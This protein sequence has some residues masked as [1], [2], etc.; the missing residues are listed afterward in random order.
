MEERR[1]QRGVRARP[2]SMALSACGLLHDDSKGIVVDGQKEE[3]IHEI[4]GGISVGGVLGQ[5]RER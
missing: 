1:L 4:L 2:W 5:R 3:W